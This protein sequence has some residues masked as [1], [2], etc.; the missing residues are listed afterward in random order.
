[1]AVTNPRLLQAT[2]LEEP[3]ITERFIMSIQT[4]V[5][6][7][8]TAA[9]SLPDLIKAKR[10]E[11]SMTQQELA[12]AAKISIS[13]VKH[14]ET[15]RQEPTMP[16]M[17]AIAAALGMSPNEIWAELDVGQPDEDRLRLSLVQDFSAFV[18][19]RAT[20]AQLKQLRTFLAPMIDGSLPENED[21]PETAVDAL[22]ALVKDRGLKARVL[23][24]FLDAAQEELDELDL[25]DLE[26]LA[27]ELRLSLPEMKDQD[28]SDAARTILENHILVEALYTIDLWRTDASELEDL[29]K[30][31]NSAAGREIIEDEGF[32]EA[33]DK[34]RDRL[35][36]ELPVQLIE[37]AKARKYLS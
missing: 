4:G 29:R 35:L 18:S 16:K 20:G 36:K 2:N 33:S 7:S 34:Y 14:Y 8:N 27:F 13:A 28:D 9:M 11:R 22:I 24:R 3:I 26:T 17:R 25:D 23:P 1:M 19:S 5:D 15:G 10:A 21:E 31:V 30:Q 32:L 12:D 37:L 6:V